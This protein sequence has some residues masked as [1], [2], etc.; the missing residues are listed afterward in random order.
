MST[1]TI[2]TKGQI[3]IP[4]DVRDALHIMPGQKFSVEVIDGDGIV[5]R[6]SRSGLDLLRTPVRPWKGGRPISKE[7]IEDAIGDA[8]DEKLARSRSVTKAPR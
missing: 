2:S 5:L 8:M 7:D 1:A 3:V 4:Q 6:P